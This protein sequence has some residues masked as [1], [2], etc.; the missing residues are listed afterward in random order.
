[1]MIRIFVFFGEIEERNWTVK[2]DVKLSGNVLIELDVKKI[3]I[4]CLKFI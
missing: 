2:K 4:H 3:E 1:M